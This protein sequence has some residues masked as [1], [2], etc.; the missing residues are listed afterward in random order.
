MDGKCLVCDVY[1]R[2]WK[3]VMM[4]CVVLCVTLYMFYEE[5]S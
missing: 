5:G 3:G 1:L 2:A 4:S